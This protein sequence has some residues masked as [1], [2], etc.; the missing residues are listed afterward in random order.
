MKLFELIQTSIRDADIDYSNNALKA[1]QDAMYNNSTKVKDKKGRVKK[2]TPTI[3]RLGKGRYGRAMAMKNRPNTVI[4]TGIIAGPNSDGYYKYISTLARK[5]W[6]SSNPY[7][8]RVYALKT[9]HNDD[10]DDM[11]AAEIERLEDISKVDP[12]TLLAIGDRAFFNFEQ[13][14][15][16]EMRGSHGHKQGKA[17]PT[18]RKSKYM[19]KLKALPQN[20]LSTYLNAEN[21]AETISN[22]IA[23]ALMNNKLETIKDPLLKQALMIVKKLRVADFDVHLGNIMVRHGPGGGQLVLT[24]PIT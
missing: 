19:P 17:S 5:N 4:K 1:V 24:D 20:R 9:Y 14:V 21:V 23:H 2:R 7:L 15:N 22:L 11:Y 10:G 13:E 8:P 16:S 3:E 6:S 18:G 12:Q